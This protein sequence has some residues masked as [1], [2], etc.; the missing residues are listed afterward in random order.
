LIKE[1]KNK[2]VSPEWGFPKGR[3]NTK[4]T[5]LECARREFAEETGYTYKDYSLVKKKREPVIFKE[6]FEATNGVWYSHIY[7]LARMDKTVHT[8]EVDMTNE[9]Q[10][11]EVKDI[12]W[13]GVEEAFKMIRGYD[14]KKKEVLASVYRYLSPLIRVGR[15]TPND[16][17]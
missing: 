17:L 2:W 8:P 13:F 5:N 3:K 4:E 1:S 12:G 16:S 9:V 7:Y 6:I 14:I 11:G 10:A 15:Y